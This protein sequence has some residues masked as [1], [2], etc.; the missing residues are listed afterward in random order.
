[1]DVANLQHHLKYSICH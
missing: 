1:M